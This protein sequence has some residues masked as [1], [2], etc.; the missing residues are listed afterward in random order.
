M[1]HLRT[2][3]VNGVSHELRTPLAAV[4][5]NLDLLRLGIVPP[6]QSDECL[7]TMAHETERLSHLIDNVLNFSRMERG[8]RSYQLKRVEP[9]TVAAEMQRTLQPLLQRDGFDLHVHV[10]EQ[11]P[12]INADPDALMQAIINLLSNA[13]KFSGDAR[14][15][16]L[17]FESRNG[18][19]IL[20]VTDR[21]RGISEGVR[22]HIFEKFYRAPDVE[23]EGITGAGIGLTLVADIA[24]GHHGGV[25][26]ES[27]VGRGSTFSI[28][29]PA[30]P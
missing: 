27:E 23:A 20:S 26:V 11:L 6:E 22:P 28:I 1:A 7:A 10:A 15:I 8:T 30:A 18:N 12:A 3:F 29:L 9:G 25:H 4:R 13:M 5:V 2:Q 19:V 24:R 17:A 16:E 21:G 14:H